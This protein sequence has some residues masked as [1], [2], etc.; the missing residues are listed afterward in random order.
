MTSIE[1]SSAFRIPK[2]GNFNDK[3]YLRELILPPNAFYSLEIFKKDKII[4]NTIF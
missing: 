1:T 3:S 4:A 2:C